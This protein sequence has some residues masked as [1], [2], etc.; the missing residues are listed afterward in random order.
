MITSFRLANSS[1]GHEDLALHRMGVG[2][3]KIEW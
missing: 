1:Q 3:K 2:V